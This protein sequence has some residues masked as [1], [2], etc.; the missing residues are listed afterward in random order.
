[1]GYEN[2]QAANNICPRCNANLQ[3][4]V[5]VSCGYTVPQQQVP[6]TFQPAQ[7]APVNVYV[8]PVQ[9]PFAGAMQQTKQISKIAYILLTFFLGWLGVHRFM[10]GQIGI[11]IIYL[12][13]FGGFGIAWLIDFII[14]LTKLSNYPNSENYEFALAPRGYWTR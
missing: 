4:G 1:M 10:R 5:C 7:N 13:T 9:Q 8:Q 2:Q 3:N 12:L 11:G 14:S 6:Q